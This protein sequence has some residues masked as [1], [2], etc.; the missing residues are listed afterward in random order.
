MPKEIRIIVDSREQKPWNFDI[1][2]KK[3]GRYTTVIGQVVKG[4]TSCDYSVE[5][6]EDLI[7][8]ERKSGFKE[9]FINY[10]PLENKT[11]FEA[12]WQRIMH[13]PHKYLIIEGFLTQDVLGLGI[14]QFKTTLPCS[15]IT[16]WI[17]G[18]AQDYNFTPIFTGDCGKRIARQLFDLTIRKYGK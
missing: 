2:E 8:I 6:Y 12:E 14:P 15:R 7:L 11:R 1:E 18:L 9:L 4:L 16:E 3:S 13:V 5:G 17:Y 10:T